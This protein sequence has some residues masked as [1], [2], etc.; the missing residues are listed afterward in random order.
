MK[1]MKNRTEIEDHVY[2]I[3]DEADVLI[4]N[5]YM[6]GQYKHGGHL[7]EETAE[8]LL[9]EAI[10]EAVDMVIYLL[11]LREKI[12]KRYETAEDDWGN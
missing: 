9:E 10:D 8:D 7:W 6:E 4:Y 11:T 2:D 12:E 1:S 3:M 5:K